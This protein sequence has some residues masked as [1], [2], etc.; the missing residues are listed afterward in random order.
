MVLAF[1]SDMR[2]DKFT[3]HDYDVLATVLF[4]I[5]VP[6]FALL[7]IIH[8]WSSV[9]KADMKEGSTDTHTAKLQQAFGRLRYG[10]DNAEDRRLLAD[11][12]ARVED[13][14]TLALVFISVLTAQFTD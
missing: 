7:C 5:F 2:G 6:A 1:K 8:K 10:R 4:V 3:K 13:E 12:I 14:V 9:V 11:Y